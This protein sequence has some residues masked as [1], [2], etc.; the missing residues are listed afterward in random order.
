MA[1]VILATPLRQMAGQAKEI[2]VAAGRLE[3]IL[4]EIRSSYPQLYGSIADSGGIK[5]FVNVYLNDQDVRSI[6]GLATEVGEK[7]SLMVIPAVAGG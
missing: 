1:R 2:Q 5:R 4:S 7:D 6:S 3:D